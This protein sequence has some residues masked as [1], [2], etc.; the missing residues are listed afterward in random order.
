[1]LNVLNVKSVLFLPLVVSLS[2]QMTQVFLGCMKDFLSGM[3]SSGS[4]EAQ[5]RSLQHDIELMQW[6]H[7][8]ELSELRYNTGV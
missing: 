8:Q 6:R 1:M 4:L 2:L 5:V 3:G 7:Q